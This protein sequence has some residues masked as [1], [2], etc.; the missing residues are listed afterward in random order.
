M[1]KLLRASALAGFLFFA[2]NGLLLAEG[3]TGRAALQYFEKRT[4]S[5]APTA[6]GSGACR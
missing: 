3:I 4:R 2:G 5:S 1:T 6:G